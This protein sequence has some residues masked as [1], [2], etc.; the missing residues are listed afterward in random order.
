VFLA[1]L[2][3]SLALQWFRARKRQG[4]VRQADP[5]RLSSEYQARWN[6][7]DRGFDPLFKDFRKL[8][9]VKKNLN[10]FP[11]EIGDSWRRY[12]RISRLEM[13]VTSGMVLFALTAFRIC[14]S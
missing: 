2:A 8:Q 1:L 12:R 14:A 5:A 9:L 7:S 10:R 6:R 3:A 11:A 13:A 4:L